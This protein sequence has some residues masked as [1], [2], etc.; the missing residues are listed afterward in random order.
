MEERMQKHVYDVVVLGTGAAGLTAALRAAAG[1]ARVG[2]FEKADTVGGTSAW[3]GGT[4]WLPNNRHE[5]ELGFSDSR[6]EVLTYLMSLSHGLMERP[7]VEAYVDTAPEVAAWLEDNSPVEFETLRGMSDY[8]PEHPGGKQEGR[9]LECTLFPFADLG[10]WAHRVTVGWQITGEITM[11]ESSL[12][13]KAPDGVPQEELDR[14]KRRDERGA[15]QAL[16]GRLLKGCLDRGVH[17]QVRC[18][19]VRLLIGD[20][21]VTGVLIEGPD[22]PFEARARGGVVLATGG[23]EHDERLVRAFLRGPLARAVSVPTNTGDGLR[24]AMRVGAD[25]ADMREAWWVPTIDVDVDGWGRVPWQVNTER[26]RPHTIMVND[27]GARFTNEAANYNALGNAFHVVDVPRFAYVNHP[28]WLVLDHHFLS[29]YGLAGHRPPAPTPDWMIEA[30]TIA[31]LAE[32]IGVPVRA[33]QA[34]VERWNG[35]VAAGSDPD[36]HRGDSHHDRAWGD[37]AFGGTR[38]GTLGPIDSPPYYAVRVR[39]GAL[40]TKGG[41]RTDTQGRALDVDGNVIEG[42]Y[43]AGNAMGSVM[44]MTYGGHGGTLGP[45]LV[46][47]YLSGRHA[48]LAVTAQPDRKPQSVI[49]G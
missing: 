27:D 43:A 25:L 10:D 15:G 8:H 5:V 40:G 32:R 3:S 48:A 31:G 14:R 26:T 22:G 21:R 20:G 41:P 49:G 44:G 1:G 24:M 6:E 23:F 33:L 36:Y 42:L 37:P 46:F 19:G 38:Q 35:N 47:G 9:S 16:V 18:R 34:T 17:P 30:P 7:L 28:A 11:S 2:L 13:R 4:V 45:G 29:R 12:G 39:C